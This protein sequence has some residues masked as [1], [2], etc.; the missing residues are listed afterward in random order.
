MEYYTAAK[1]FVFN[2]DT[3]S[4][5][6]KENYDDHMA[7]ERFMLSNVGAF[8][9]ELLSSVTTWRPGQLCEEPTNTGNCQEEA[10]DRIDYIL[11]AMFWKD[12]CSSQVNIGVH[13]SD[14]VATNPVDFS[15][16][17]SDFAPEDIY[18]ARVR[19]RAS[20]VERAFDVF[21]SMDTALR[22]KDSKDL[23]GVRNF[24]YGE[25]CF[26]SFYPLLR[27]VKPQPGEVFYDLGCGTGLPSA[28]AAIMFPEL[29]ASNG[30][31][32][33]ETLVGKGQEAIS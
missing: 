32:F 15:I 23:L 7:P 14:P 9:A 24:T 6:Y 28:I 30:A 29:A 1:C 31:E 13:L 10:P 20:I 16:K 3:N 8:D 2:R 12:A 27:L 18:D 4:V 21:D 25:V 5:Q 17:V 26:Y 19:E 33:L 22:E 11:S